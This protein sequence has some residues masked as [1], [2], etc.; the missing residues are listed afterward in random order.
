VPSTDP[1]EGF[2]GLQQWSGPVIF[3]R[4]FSA[5]RELTSDFA[6]AY[7][8]TRLHAQVWRALIRG[9][10]AGFEELRD[11]LVAALGDCFLTLDHLADV[12]GEIMIELLEVVPLALPALAA[13]RESLSSRPDGARRPIAAGAR[14]CLTQNRQRRRSI[15]STMSGGAHAIT[16][17]CRFAASLHGRPRPRSPLAACRR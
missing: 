12:D 6:V 9:D 13:D 1:S 10:M 14:G 2:S 16:M 3:D 8:L 7:S 15:P 17:R 5:Y 4:L 11:T